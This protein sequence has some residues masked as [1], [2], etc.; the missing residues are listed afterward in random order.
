MSNFIQVTVN[1]KPA[2]IRKDSIFTVHE[3]IEDERQHFGVNAGITMI[4]AMYGTCPEVREWVVME[5][6][7]T[8]M[9]KMDEL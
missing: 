1:D 5:S 8:V 4:R 6:A 9:S 2:Y 7:I 3:M